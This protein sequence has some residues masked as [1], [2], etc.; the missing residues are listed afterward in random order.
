MLLDYVEIDQVL[1]NLV[2][3]AAKYTPPRAVTSRYQSVAATT[4]SRSV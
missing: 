2:E 1:T 4:K 3:N